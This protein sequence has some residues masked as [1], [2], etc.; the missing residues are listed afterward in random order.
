M[1]DAFHTRAEVHPPTQTASS[2]A[3]CASRL[4]FILYSTNVV[5]S[6]SNREHFYRL[7]EALQQAAFTFGFYCSHTILDVPCLLL[8]SHQPHTN[9]ISTHNLQESKQESNKH[10]NTLTLQT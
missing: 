9:D 4:P 10:Q 7:C 1:F 3:T 2:L 5:H 6:P 8:D